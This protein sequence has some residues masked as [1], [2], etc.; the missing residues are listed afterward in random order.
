[1][2]IVCR[3]SRQFVAIPRK[4]EN[5][6]TQRATVTLTC[7]LNR[8]RDVPQ[9]PY[10]AASTLTLEIM[11]AVS[12]MGSKNCLCHVAPV[13]CSLTQAG[14]GALFA[15][16]PIGAI[17]PRLDPHGADGRGRDR[18]F[19]RRPAQI[20]TYSYYRIRLL[21]RVLGVEAFVG[22]ELLIDSLAANTCPTK[23]Q[24]R[25]LPTDREAAGRAGHHSQRTRTSHPFPAKNSS[26]T[27][28]A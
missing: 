17:P 14:V 23:G 27:C 24:R 1:M 9:P 2:G 11:V 6:A 20:R 12:V 19:G 5:G 16:P 25:S 4:W 26:S 10:T 7:T 15:V 28:S 13:P 21:L 22:M 3:P 8:P 18:P